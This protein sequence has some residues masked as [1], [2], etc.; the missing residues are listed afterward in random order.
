MN[1]WL[2]L[3][4]H[5]LFGANYSHCLRMCGADGTNHSYCIN[6]L[7]SRNKAS[8]RCFFFVCNK[9]MALPG[10]CPVKQSSLTDFLRARKNESKTPHRIAFLAKNCPVWCPNLLLGVR[11]LDM[12]E[13]LTT[14]VLSS[15]SV[16]QKKLQCSG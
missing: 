2:K 4:W 6:H 15:A 7:L 9:E 12:L 5:I 14:Q 13:A 1:H 11:G 3:A 16:R 10:G 8:F